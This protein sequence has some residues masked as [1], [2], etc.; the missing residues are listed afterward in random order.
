MKIDNLVRTDFEVVSPEVMLSD[1]DEL[2]ANY[3]SL[4]IT[5]KFLPAFLFHFN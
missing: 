5:F 3:S 2:P 1:L 4:E